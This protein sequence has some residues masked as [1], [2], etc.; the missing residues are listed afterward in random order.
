MTRILDQILDEKLTVRLFVEEINLSGDRLFPTGLVTE[1]SF[2]DNLVWKT[3]LDFQKSATITINNCLEKFTTSLRHP[4]KLVPSEIVDDAKLLSYCKGLHSEYKDKIQTYGGTLKIDPESFL[5]EFENLIG[6]NSLESYVYTENN[7]AFCLVPNQRIWI[8]SESSAVDYARDSSINKKQNIWAG[9][10]GGFTK[11]NSE[12][13]STI[14]INVSGLS[15][16]LELTNIYENY[17]LLAYTGDL[18]ESYVTELNKNLYSRFKGTQ[19][20]T[21]LKPISFALLPVFLANYFYTAQGNK[22]DYTPST[23][24]DPNFFLQDVLWLLDTDANN[25]WDDIV[26]GSD[27]AILGKLGK[28]NLSYLVSELFAGNEVSVYDLLPSVYVDPL[29]IEIFNDKSIGVVPLLIQQTFALIDDSSVTGKDLLTKTAQSIMG[30][31]Y[32]DDFGNICLEVS[33]TWSSPKDSDPFNENNGFIVNPDYRD[34]QYSSLLSDIGHNKDYII[35][36][37]DLFSSAK[38]FSEGNLVTHVEVPAGLNFNTE[39]GELIQRTRLTG[40]TGSSNEMVLRMQTKYGVRSLTTE[41]LTANTMNLNKADAGEFKKALDA[42]AL[43]TL[44]L[45]NYSAT[46]LSINTRFLSH[47]SVGKN[48]LVL[49]EEVLALINSKTFSYSIMEEGASYSCAFV[50]SYVHRIDDKVVYPFFDIVLG[51]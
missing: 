26:N 34:S 47:L 28:D 19:M 27:V 3:S 1:V 17:R 45:R 25:C 11:T 50:L 29:F 12:T 43:S 6:V 32:E 51:E 36:D 37:T 9:M 41:S 39:F 24:V 16:F 31:A 38:A 35:A 21:A 44:Q 13:D 5:L 40:V 20:L 30:A 7:K 46:A 22:K 49:S 14:T 42:F 33:R 15:R 8:V 18:L 2:F 23:E 48:V 10:I 4:D